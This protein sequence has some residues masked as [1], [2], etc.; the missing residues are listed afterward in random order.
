M[1]IVAE[2]T[3]DPA[4][5]KRTESADLMGQHHT[6]TISLEDEEGD[7]EATARVTVE[8]DSGSDSGGAIRNSSA[9]GN[10]SN[11]EAKEESIPPSV[12][13]PRSYPI[14]VG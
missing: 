11:R 9:P 3:G 1:R 7:S 10:S 4:A 5:P 8:Y 13:R 2:T 6:T 14:L 12:C